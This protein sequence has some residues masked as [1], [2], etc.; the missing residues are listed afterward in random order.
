MGAFRFKSYF[1]FLG[2]NKL[3]TAINLF[4]FAVSLAVV[5]LLGLYVKGELSVDRFHKDYD[6]IFLLGA[7]KSELFQTLP[8]PMAHD[9]KAQFPEIDQLARVMYNS[10]TAT[11]RQQSSEETT[12]YTDPSFFGVFSF[13]LVEGEPLGQLKAA[14]EVAISRSLAT[15]LFGGEKALYQTIDIGGAPYVVTGVV[16]DFSNTHLAAPGIILR[17]ENLSADMYDSYSAFQ[18]YFYV[19]QAPGSDLAAKMDGISAFMKELCRSKNAPTPELRLVPLADN[20]FDAG[21][22]PNWGHRGNDRA[23][24]GVLLAAMISLWL[25][26]M[27]N[28]INLSVAQSG[29]RAREAA[30]RRLLG[31]SRGSLVGSYIAESTLFCAF[32]FLLGMALA[33]AAEPLFNKLFNASTRVAE[34]LT[35]PVWP[36]FL[37]GIALMGVLS[38]I[39]P[40]TV[41]ARYQPIDV[42]R[43]LLTRK[44]RQGYARVFI[45]LQYTITIILIASTLTIMRQTRFMRHS[46]PGF[47]RENVMVVNRPVNGTQVDALRGKLLL[48][49]GVGQVA[50]SRGGTP[51]QPQMHLITNVPEID[52]SFTYWEFTVDSLYMDLLGIRT[53]HES[54]VRQPDAIWLNQTAA[55]ALGIDDQAV[56]AMDKPLAGIVQDFHFADFTKPI[57]PAVFRRLPQGER[58][59]NVTVKIAG[60][61]PGATYREVMAVY[62]EFFGEEPRSATFMDEA[63]VKWYD[64]QQRTYTIIGSFALIAVVIAALGMLAMAT[65]YLRQRTAEIAIRKVF[66]STDGE[67]LRRVV[68]SFM[69][70]VLV[71]FVLAIPVIWYAMEKWLAGY[72]YHIPLGWTTF[73]LAGVIAFAVAF[74]AVFWQSW[75][76]TRANPVDSLRKS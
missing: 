51:I 29:I 64:K 35:W 38:G 40:A 58:A 43:G 55:R 62:K 75:T 59:G 71:A 60:D 21:S 63:T 70:M 30:T 19:K 41:V 36:L 66:G 2:R 24:I 10:A 44:T 74:A 32:A 15:R 34:L 1:T 46:N 56:T 76:A 42:V 72:A 8:G 68:L 49:P 67:V 33:S 6:Q 9:L 23:F 16:E 27:I 61:D 57:E 53:V 7:E 17:V 14:N 47:D 65:Y 26:A 54:G 11:Y 50:F 48:I 37:A 28:Y 18:F 31:S 45:C 12:L 22:T 52:G 20:Y 3:Y 39:I 5:I 73:A 4:G 13:P 25:F 69:R